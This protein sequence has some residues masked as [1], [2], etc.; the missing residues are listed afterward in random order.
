MFSGKAAKYLASMVELSSLELGQT[1]VDDELGVALQRMT[2]LG[3]LDLEDTLVTD[4]ALDGL[5]TQAPIRSIRLASTRV[6]DRTAMRIARLRAIS[7]V[8]NISGTQVTDLGS[9]RSLGALRF[10]RWLSMGP[11]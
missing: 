11:A 1:Q 7:E 2:N 4:A 6:G 10:A 3:V 5:P 8:D 9:S